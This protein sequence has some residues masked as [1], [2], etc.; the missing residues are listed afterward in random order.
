M[1][2]FPGSPMVKNLPWGGKKKES[3]LG[4]PTGS[5]V[6]NPSA[7]AGDTGLIPDPRRSHMP[8]SNEAH[9]PQLL[10]LCSRAR[11]PQLLSPRATLLKPA[12][13]RVCALQ[14]EKPLQREARVL[15]LESRLHSP[16]KGKAHTATRTQHRQK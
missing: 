10:R 12:L 9:M 6:K 4:F 16:N 2:D 11:E 5:V 13:P 14:Q 3:T 1:E 8:G 7:N 15:Q